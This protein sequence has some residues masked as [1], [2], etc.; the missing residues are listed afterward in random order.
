MGVE[1]ASE[2]R[3]L[4]EDE[5]AMVMRSHFPE[6]D[7]ASHEDLVGL[8]Q[9]LRARRGRARDIVQGRRRIQRG[10]ADTRGTATETAS[11]RGL[12]AKKQVFSR[13][14]KRVN[15]RLAALSAQ[16]RRERAVE[17]MRAALARQQQ[18]PVHHP[19]PGA[20]GHAGMTPKRSGMRRGIITGG[21]IGSTSQAG[22]NAQAARDSRG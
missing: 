2:R 1:F 3:L 11:E 4:A 6:L 10:K 12:A 16:A 13:G 7:A 21:R 15:T 22:R 20:T 5:I 9:W 8:A 18:T 14:L 17:S 19:A